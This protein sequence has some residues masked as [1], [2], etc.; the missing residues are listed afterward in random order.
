MVVYTLFHQ[1]ARGR[2]KLMQ[3]EPE[4]GGKHEKEDN[5]GCFCA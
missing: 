2:R 4:Q 1:K 5:R 3:T